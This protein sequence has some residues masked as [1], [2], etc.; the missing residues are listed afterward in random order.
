MHAATWK[1]FSPNYSSGTSLVV[2]VIVGW[3]MTE[4]FWLETVEAIQ[5]SVE[6]DVARP[7]DAIKSMSGLH[8]LGLK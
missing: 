2:V 7:A 5:N 4:L 8:D 1:Q 3:P 6:V